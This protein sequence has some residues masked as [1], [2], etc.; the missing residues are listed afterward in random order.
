MLQFFDNMKKLI[1]CWVQ[2][3]IALL[4]QTPLQKKAMHILPFHI[5]LPNMD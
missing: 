2:S 3:F 4:I 5:Q 1:T